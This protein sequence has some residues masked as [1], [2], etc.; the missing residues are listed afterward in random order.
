MIFYGERSM[1]NKNHSILILVLIILFIA[2][3]SYGGVKFRDRQRVQQFESEWEA[4]GRNV[5][6]ELPG[7]MR[8]KYPDI[9]EFSVTVTRRLNKHTY[10]NKDYQWYYKFHNNIRA[11]AAMDES[12]EALTEA[13]RCE[14]VEEI[15]DS[16]RAE[17]VLIRSEKTPLYDGECRKSD[18][19]LTKDYYG[20][21]DTEYDLMVNAADNWYDTEPSPYGY[22]K[23]IR[24]GHGTLYEYTHEFGTEYV[25][26]SAEEIVRRELAE[27]EARKRARQNNVSGKSSSGSKSG[28]SSSYGGGSSYG[29]SKNS[30]KKKTV[31]DQDPYD[32][33][34][35]DV[36]LDYD[37]D[38]ERYRTDDD[39]A[40]GVDDAMDDE[41]WDW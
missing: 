9:T 26:M 41:G 18:I 31:Y 39:Y 2:G 30:S 5:E 14:R 27:K 10:G 35:E 24:D 32:A 8:A 33:G 7:I 12:F 37:Y 16:M 19:N 36:Y 4:F 3:A 29:S 1:A 13:K 17:A 11:W 20:V 25:W 28:S 21:D 34:Y 15:Y 23:H 40:R 38:E 6:N 22:L